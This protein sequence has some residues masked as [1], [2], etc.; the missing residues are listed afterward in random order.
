MEPVTLVLT[1]LAAGAAAGLTNT[2]QAAVTDAYQALKRLVVGR[3]TSA[4]HDAAGAA[5]LVDEAG[6]AETATTTLTEAL[7]S[8]GVD[9]PTRD[10]AQALLDLLDDRKGKYVVDASQ[11]KGV[12][13]G[14]HS[15]QHNTFN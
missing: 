3:L 6:S 1:A 14:D 4:G 15:T 11:A 13:I 5:D 7:T 8:A 12:L 2:A 9:D 10:A